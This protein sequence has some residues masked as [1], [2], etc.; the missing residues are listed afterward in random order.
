MDPVHWE[1]RLSDSEI[2]PAA[3]GPGCNISSGVTAQAVSDHNCKGLV[4]EQ[5]I[6]LQ[7]LLAE[8]LKSRHELQKPLIM[9]D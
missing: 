2:S 6:E 7:D 5:V 4:E 8:K 1:N 3:R 9:T